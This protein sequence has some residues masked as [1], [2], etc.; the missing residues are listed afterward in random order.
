MKHKH[1]ICGQSIFEELRRQ[2]EDINLSSEDGLEQISL[3]DD[4][5]E[6]SETE[7]L[8]QSGVDLP[9]PAAPKNKRDENEPLLVKVKGGLNFFGKLKIWTILDYAAGIKWALRTLG[10]RWKAHKYN[11]RGEYFFPN[12]R[13]VEILAANPSDILPVEW[14]A[15]VDHYMD[16]KTKKLGRPVCR[17][18]VIVST[19]LK[20]DGSYISGEGQRLAVK[21]LSEDQERAA[22]E[23]I[24][25]KVLAHPDDAIVKVCGPENDKRVRDFSNAACLS[26]FVKSKR[27][28]GGTI[29]GS[30]SSVSQQHVADLK[31]Q[32]Q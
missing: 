12:K 5:D 10:D 28:F 11:L 16:P 18:E 26:G 27:I 19:L 3:N 17:S 23:G 24:H 9:E 6:I 29:C 15:F 1:N 13:K 31:R 2:S 4:G 32:L 25:S 30:S 22:T 20:K 14:T 21:Y 8:N 7:M